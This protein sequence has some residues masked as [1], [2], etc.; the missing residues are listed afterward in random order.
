MSRISSGD[1]LKN[2]QPEQ[3]IYS[4]KVNNNPTT[5]TPNTT[6]SASSSANVTSSSANVTSSSANVTSSLATVTSSLAT[7]T[8]TNS[9]SSFL[10]P[11]RISSRNRIENIDFEQ[12]EINTSSTPS[13]MLYT[14]NSSSS[15]YNSCDD[16]DDDDDNNTNQPKSS[17]YGV[18][19]QKLPKKRTKSKRPD[20]VA[21]TSVE[22]EKQLQDGCILISGIY[23]EVIFNKT[24]IEIASD[25]AATIEKFVEKTCKDS[26]F[27]KKYPNAKLSTPVDKKQKNILRIKELPVVSTPYLP[28][29]QYTFCFNVTKPWYYE[30]YIGISLK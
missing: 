4:P 7:A 3:F 21:T 12:E 14:N 5:T 29:Q 28:G 30:G 27:I 19:I 22:L 17:F 8:S 20:D 15:S 26:G 18:A 2:Y 25:L 9:S 6:S 24:S 13:S 10:A 23:K 11:T 16:D 1:R